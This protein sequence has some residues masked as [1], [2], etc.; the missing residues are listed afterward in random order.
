MQ[1]AN[2]EYK[3]YKQ[4]AGTWKSNDGAC[5][6]K[7]TEHVGIEVKYGG[8]VL[9]GTYGVLPTGPMAGYLPQGYMGYMGMSGFGDM[10]A[11]RDPSEDIQIKLGDSSLKNGDQILYTIDYAWHDLSD[12]LH[13]D[14]S[15]AATGGKIN[16]ILFREAAPVE[17][18]NLKDGEVQC[19]C[20]QIFSSKFCPNC[21]AM[22][23]EKNTF[24]CSCG[25]TGQ[26]SRF[27]P[28]CGKPC[29]AYKPGMFPSSGSA[30]SAS[31][32]Q[33]AASGFS[34][35]GKKAKIEHGWRDGRGQFQ[36]RF[37]GGQFSSR[38][39]VT[40]PSGPARIEMP[41]GE[42]YRIYAQYAF[43]P[44]TGEGDGAVWPDPSRMRLHSEEEFPVFPKRYLYRD[45][46]GKNI[47]EIEKIWYGAGT[48]HMD[49]LKWEDS[50]K[51][52]VDLELDEDVSIPEP[53][54]EP[55]AGW[56]CSQCGATLQ[57]GEKCTECGAEIKTEMLFAL[58]EYMTTNPPRSKTIRVYKFSDTQLILQ[59][60][61]N[62][63]FIPATVIEP[64]MEIIRK[65][66][67]DKWEEYKDRLT[68]L[69][70]GSMSVSYMDGDKW[71]GTSTDHMLSAGAAYSALE[72][73][74]TT[75]R[76]D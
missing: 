8:A 18:L 15:E 27:C 41:T 67:I 55:V 1:I 39:V 60:G 17:P 76:N 44:W 13:I 54:P 6:V 73:L 33:S 47:Y 10:A 23:K 5:V 28:E 64:A 72:T 62:F 49:L 52:T 40:A 50:S 36:L 9:T 43:A 30:A 4:L 2:P 70:G 29:S 68:G 24:T 7:L 25:Y 63:R 38:Y 35:E 32:A 46:T 37:K 53:E 66:E 22:R 20:G 12:R 11:K 75:A 61:N 56:T 14:L 65:Y 21:G 34:D 71:C 31:A 42:E 51:F 58:S 16:L 74:F 57:T 45:K 19:E 26:I 69:M 48:L 59:N 3:Y